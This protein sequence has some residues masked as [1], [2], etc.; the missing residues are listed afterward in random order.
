MGE[1]NH[2]FSYLFNAMVSKLYGKSINITY[3]G[4]ALAGLTNLIRV[5]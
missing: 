2:C 5:Y 1:L 4:W 3:K